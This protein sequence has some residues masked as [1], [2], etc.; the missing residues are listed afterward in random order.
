MGVTLDAGA[1]IEL[2]RSLEFNHR[3]MK[4]HLARISHR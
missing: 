4:E 2:Q 1:L 3:P